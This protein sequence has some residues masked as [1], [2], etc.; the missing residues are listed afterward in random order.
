MGAQCIAC[1]CKLK[2]PDLVREFVPTRAERGAQRDGMFF[3]QPHG[4]GIALRQQR[5]EPLE[6]GRQGFRIQE[7]RVRRPGNRRGRR[8]RVR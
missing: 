1:R 4:G 7:R 2:P 3:K 6:Q 8:Q 5:V